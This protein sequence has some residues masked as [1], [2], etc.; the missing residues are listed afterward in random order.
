MATHVK[1]RVYF[2]IFL[3]VP[4]LNVI[5]G[6]D[7]TPAWGGIDTYRRGISI[8]YA[9]MGNVGLGSIAEVCSRTGRRSAPGSRADCQCLQFIPR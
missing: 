5:V 3:V 9:D 4:L 1:A 2:S 7:F 8:K 6:P